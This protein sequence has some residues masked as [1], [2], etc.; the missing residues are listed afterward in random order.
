MTFFIVFVLF[1][2]VGAALVAYG[3]FAKN[4]WGINSD[5]VF[6]PRCRAL[7]PTLYEPRSL[8]QAMW[9]GWTC[10]VCGAGVDKWGREVVPNAPQTVVRPESEMREVLRKR[11]I[12]S[13][14]VIFCVFI[15]LD[16][17]GLSGRRFPSS[18][19]EALIQICVNIV[20]TVILTA[21][22]YFIRI[23]GLK[24]VPPEQNE[25]DSAQGDQPGRNRG[26]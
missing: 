4:R 8:S 11:F 1:L 15:A 18:W 12:F 17:T 26:K 7:L 20:W 3:T 22:F 13:A 10:P 25:R 14:P 19:A 2:I 6:C 9:G 23:R 21:T 24:R 16:W 5:P